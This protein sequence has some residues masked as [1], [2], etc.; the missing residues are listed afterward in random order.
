MKTTAKLVALLAGL[1]VAGGL[2]AATVSVSTTAPTVDGADIANDSGASDADGS[3]DWGHMW[4]NRP[5]QGQT[6]VTG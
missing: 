4:S 1:A 5:H 2:H 6:F 3:G